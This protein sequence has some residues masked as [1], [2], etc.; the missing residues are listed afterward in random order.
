MKPT[1][2]PESNTVYGENQKE[3]SNLPAYKGE[4]VITCWRLTPFERLQVAIT[5]KVWFRGLTFGDPL[6]PQI[7]SIEN[8]FRRPFWEKA[9]GYWRLSWGLCP[10]C[11][12]DAPEIDKCEICF[13]YGAKHSETHPPSERVKRQWRN[14]W[15]GTPLPQEDSQ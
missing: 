2:F 6:Q 12:S 10:A 13:S 14:R 3:Y 8:P 11:N 7:L 4:E 9:I 1:Q 15:D 5:G